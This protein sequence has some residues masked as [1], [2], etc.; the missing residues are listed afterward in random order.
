MKFVASSSLPI[1]LQHHV[2]VISNVLVVATHSSVFS[3]S[4]SAASASSETFCFSEEEVNCLLL[5]SEQQE[6]LEGYL[7]SCG[8]DALKSE[9]TQR[10]DIILGRL[11]F[12]GTA[13][14]HQ[15]DQFRQFEQQQPRFTGIAK[16]NHC[17]STDLCFRASDD[18]MN[19]VDY[20]ISVSLQQ[21]RLTGFGSHSAY[22]AVE[23]TL[24][25]VANQNGAQD[26]YIITTLREPGSYAPK[27]YAFRHTWDAVLPELATA[28]FEEWLDMAPWRTN[29]LTRM[30]GAQPDRLTMPKSMLYTKGGVTSGGWATHSDEVSKFLKDEYMIHQNE[31]GPEQSEV[32]VT[33]V[34]RLNEMVHF[35][36][37][38]RLSDTWKLMEHTFCWTMGYQSY[39]PDKEITGYDALK[40]HLLPPGQTTDAV[41][42]DTAKRIWTKLKEKNRLDFALMEEAER[43]FDKRLATMQREKADGI[44]CNF[45][46]EVE[47]RCAGGDDESDERFRPTS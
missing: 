41:D 25:H 18:S 16:A 46:G 44:V 34:E 12:P 24:E 11:R 10:Q 17:P 27:W 29:V 5:D 40:M 19:D 26:Y 23:A 3:V 6:E 9:P 2:A 21:I 1:P 13:S 8:I 30:L 15:Y 14:T 33:A 31:L 20:D 7:P 28:S 38:H 39:R 45:L 35:G 37:F 36:L 47:V 32:Y 43:I 22:D 42:E 4:A